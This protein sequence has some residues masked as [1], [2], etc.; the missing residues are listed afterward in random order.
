MFD[1]EQLSC[2]GLCSFSTVRVAN[3]KP[4]SRPKTVLLGR[5]RLLDVGH[6]R[7]LSLGLLWDIKNVPSGSFL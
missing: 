1:V 2:F 5:F 4:T 7:G 6:L 3:R